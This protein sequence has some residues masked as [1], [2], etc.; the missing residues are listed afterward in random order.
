MRFSNTHLHSQYGGQH[1]FLFMASLH[2]PS[3][4]VY[5]HLCRH[6]QIS[7]I[8]EPGL[9]SAFVFVAIV[10]PTAVCSI[11]LGQKV[12]SLYE[13]DTNLGGPNRFGSSIFVV[14]FV[15]ISRAKRK[16]ILQLSHTKDYIIKQKL[17][18]M[19]L[20]IRHRIE[21]GYFLNGQDIG[22]I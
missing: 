22:M 4:P 21:G 9:G 17:M 20:E 13:P 10:L 19:I 5:N 1:Q 3:N 8:G 6:E 14:F 12:Q 7:C 15:E 11:C 18:N 2:Q 16:L